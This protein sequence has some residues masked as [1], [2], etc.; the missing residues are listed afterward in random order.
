MYKISEI[1]N[2]QCSIE[3]SFLTAKSKKI[4]FLQKVLSCFPTQRFT[5]IGEINGLDFTIEDISQKMKTPEHTILLD[6][7]G[8]GTLTYLTSDP[9]DFLLVFSSFECSSEGYYLLYLLQENNHIL[10]RTIAPL[11]NHC[12]DNFLIKLSVHSDST[13]FEIEFKD[14]YEKKRFIE[15]IK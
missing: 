1:T 9:D 10:V 15:K 7:N 2:N 8:Y 14:E 3:F 5:M 6:N 12:I 13:L 11:V 4:Q